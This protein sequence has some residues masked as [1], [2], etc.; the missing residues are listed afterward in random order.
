[1]YMYQ[2]DCPRWTILTFFLG[3]QKLKSLMIEVG[4]VICKKKK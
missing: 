4:F 2:I 3:G 1:M